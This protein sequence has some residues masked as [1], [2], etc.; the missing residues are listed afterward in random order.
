M[1]PMFELLAGE[2]NE[3]IEGLVA[4][5]L[6]KRHKRQWAQKIRDEKHRN[7]TPDEEEGFAISN[8][9]GDQ[10]DRYRKDAQDIL[11]GFA[12]SFVEDQ[13]PFIAKEAVAGE[14]IEAAQKIRKSGSF[15]S[16]LI[17]GVSSTVITSVLLAL[18]AFG[19]QV[20]GIDLIDA[21]RGGST[22]GVLPPSPTKVD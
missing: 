3:D 14:L 4:Y 13:R 9:T 21:L 15:W 16:L 2:D 11:I 17:V 7:P 1:N 6:Y 18:L 20:F 8:S 10:C 12:N 19:T 22:E 5:A